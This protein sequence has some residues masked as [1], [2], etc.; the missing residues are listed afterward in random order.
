MLSTLHINKKLHVTPLCDI[1]HQEVANAYR[2]GLLEQLRS[3]APLVPVSSLVTCLQRS[4]AVSVFDGQHQEAARDF[5]GYHFG[6]LQMRFGSLRLA[7]TL[8]NSV[9]QSSLPCQTN[10]PI[11]RQ[12]IKRRGRGW[13]NR[14]PDAT[15]NR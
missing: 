14:K 10:K 13:P 3:G 11:G 1:R 2:E 15:P 7:V 12:K 8:E 4:V 6:R 9:G 5:V